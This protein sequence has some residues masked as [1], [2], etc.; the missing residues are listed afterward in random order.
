[1]KVI[2]N[3]DNINKVSC[4]VTIGAP[5]VTFIT[6]LK[7]HKFKRWVEYKRIKH[8]VSKEN[9][10]VLIVSIGRNNIE[11]QVKLWLKE[12]KGYKTIPDERILKVEKIGYIVPKDADSIIKDL[13]KKKF[14]LQQKGIYNVHLFV[15]APIAICEMIGVEFKNNFAVFVYQYDPNSKNKY[16]LW[17]KLQR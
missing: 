11:N 10:G 14:K 9:S 13:Q 1:M 3:W 12:R 2:F 17:G 6:G 5:I 15:A 16:E 7:F 4:I 8:N